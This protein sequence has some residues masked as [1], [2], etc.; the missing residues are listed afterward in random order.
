MILGASDYVRTV[1]HHEVNGVE[2]AERSSLRT[3][4]VERNRQG[5]DFS[6]LDQFCRVDHFLR[7]DVIERA[8]LVVRS[9]FPPVLILLRQ[10]FYVLYGVFFCHSRCPSL[11]S[12]STSDRRS[13]TR[14]RTQ[15]PRTVPDFKG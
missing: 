10:F 11:S 15:M 5:N 3:F 12:L 9:P 4:V 1:L 6:L 14:V 7:G 8:E 2:A 13:S